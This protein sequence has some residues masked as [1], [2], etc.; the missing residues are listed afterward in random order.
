MNVMMKLINHKMKFLAILLLILPFLSSSQLKAQSPGEKLF[1]TNCAA[2]HRTDDQRLVGPGLKGINQK[3]TEEWLLKWIKNSQDLIKS[4]DAEA[5]AIFEEYNKTPMI[6]YDMFSDTE[7]KLIL[8]YLDDINMQDETATTATAETKTTSETHLVT[9]PKLSQEDQTLFNI[10]IVVL[11]VCALVL[12][13]LIFYARKLINDLGYPFMKVSMNHPIKFL[14]M[15]MIAVVVIYFLKIGLD[16]NVGMINILL[17]MIFP[18]VALIIFLLGSII[19]YRVSGYKVS[20]L[21]S[22]FLEGKKLFWGSQPFHLGL[23]VLFFGHLIAFLF[24]STIIAWNG[25]PV[26]LLILE[27]SAFIFALSALF[28]LIMLIR[29]RL[30]SKKLLAV[31]NNMDLLVYVVLLIQVLSGMGVAFFVRWG[32]SWF[33]SV[34]TPYLRSIFALNPQIDAVSALPWIVQIHIFSAFFILLLI[35]FTRFMHFLVAPVDYIWR[36]YQVVI[37]NWNRR[38]IRMSRKHTYGQKIRNH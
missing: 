5:I 28:G 31:S 21:S 3:R 15:I 29:R 23:L 35:P 25:E 1:K 33:A 38:A 4:G 36:S 30:T 9:D 7:I 12:I 16:Q 13:G 34:L 24:P 6:A 27:G 11:I 14:L 18:Y 20:S 22:Q 8:T 17:F 37:W 26:R 32:S 19:R 10:V 2:C